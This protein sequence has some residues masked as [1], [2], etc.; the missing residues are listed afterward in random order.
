M[1]FNWDR[2]ISVYEWT[3][4]DPP[5]SYKEMNSGAKKI[6]N[7]EQFS[8]LSSEIQQR[9]RSHIS[10][11]ELREIGKWKTG[12]HR[13]DHLLKDNNQTEVV[14]K[15]AIAFD[16]A[17][18][19]SERVETL[20]DLKGVSVPVASA[21]LT[22]YDPDHYAVVDYRALRAIARVEPTLADTTNYDDFAE[23]ANW[24]LEYKQN[25]G[26]Y[27]SFLDTVRKIS[28]RVNRTPREVDMALWVYDR[29][30]S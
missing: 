15:T 22:V 10:R 28:R 30:N 24:L 4:D 16:S 21:I 9:S 18:S 3:V 2:W 12:G 5:I 25:P 13:I 23:Y 26:V 7:D 6:E 19:D 14:T 11:P 27:S 20:R 1:S 8:S 29:D 17:L